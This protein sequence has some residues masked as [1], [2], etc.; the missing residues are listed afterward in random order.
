MPGF[1]RSGWERWLAL[2]TAAAAVLRARLF[3]HTA[4]I[5][6]LLGAGTVSLCLLLSGGALGR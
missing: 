6:C 3:P 4:Q 1:S 2:A 5:A